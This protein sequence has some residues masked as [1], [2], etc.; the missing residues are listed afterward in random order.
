MP[1]RGWGSHSR[2]VLLLERP[3]LVCHPPPPPP[4]ASP[5]R[6]PPGSPRQVGGRR[7]PPFRGRYRSYSA[8]CIVPWAGG[9]VRLP[10]EASFSSQMLWCSLAQFTS[11]VPSHMASKA[12]S[13]PSVPI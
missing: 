12:P 7:P 3:Q 1:H 9:E 2:R 11:T 6:P 4:P 13:I 8:A 10:R 5:P